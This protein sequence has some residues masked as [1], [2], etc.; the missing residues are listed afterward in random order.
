MARLDPDI[1]P[2]LA[3]YAKISASSGS[4]PNGGKATLTD[5]DIWHIG[6]QTGRD[7]EPFIQLDL[8][9]VQRIKRIVVYNRV[10]CCQKDN[11]PL[12]IEL[13][14]DAK[15]F[16]TVAKVDAAFEKWDMPVGPTNARFLRA[17]LRT[18]GELILNEIEVR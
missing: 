10:D 17:H 2:N 12:A 3:T 1:V 14:T 15:K 7:N 6:F 16:T 18:T 4:A 9:S 13:S 8:G 5:G 11:V